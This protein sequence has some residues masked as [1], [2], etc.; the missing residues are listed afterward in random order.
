MP[1]TRLVAESYPPGTVIYTLVSK[2]SNMRPL[3]DVIWGETRTGH[4]FVV[5]NFGYFGW[6]A[7]LAARDMPAASEQTQRRLG[8]RPTG[9]GLIADLELLPVSPSG[10]PSW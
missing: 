3:H 10:S 4:I 2:S 7:H 9:P 1:L 6:L 8:W 5:S